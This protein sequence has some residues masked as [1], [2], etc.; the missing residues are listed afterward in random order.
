M[1]KLALLLV[2]LMLAAVVTACGSKETITAGAEAS[3]STAASA[4]VSPSPAAE[5]AEITVTHP[6]GV[7]KVKKN[8][9]KVVVFDFSALETLD[10]LGIEVLAVP[11]ANVPS[12][13]PKYKDAA[14]YK[15]AGGLMEPNFEK[16]NEMKPDLIIISGR[17]ATSYEEFTKI[18]PTINLTLDT[19]KYLESFKTN[20]KTLGSIFSKEAEAEKELAAIEGSIKQLKDK[21][22][23]AGKNGLVV[24]VN[25]GK[26]SAY[27]VGSRFGILHGEF[28]IT[29]V[30]PK[31][32]VSTHGMSVSFEYIAEKNPDYL[33]VVDRDSVVTTGAAQQ[34]AKEVIENSLVKNTK[35]F[36]EN[37][38]VYLDANYW[39]LSGGGLISVPAMVKEVSDGL[40]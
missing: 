23:A 7:T 22:T 32:E 8:P 33:F 15:D 6:S 28:G 38:I 2:G 35:A 1:K 24:L 20:V 5:P 34:S 14:K 30:D 3:A 31:I 18:A 13:L 37:H 40:K 4:A 29:P 12:Y 19:T 27:G 21:A 36:K 10:K 11:Q 25:G 17:Q 39:Y 26:I 9:K 16:I